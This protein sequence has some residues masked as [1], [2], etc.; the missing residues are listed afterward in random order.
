MRKLLFQFIL[1]I[2]WWV[3]SGNNKI[4]TEQW[5]LSITYHDILRKTPLK[6]EKPQIQWWIRESFKIDTL[7]ILFIT[8][9]YKIKVTFILKNVFHFNNG[10]LYCGIYNIAIIH[11]SLHRIY[12][13]YTQCVKLWCLF[14][15]LNI[16]RRKKLMKI[17]GLKR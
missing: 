3:V 4:R 5:F 11:C 17:K 14:I 10:H 8:C 6:L 13:L 1:L 15:F 16:M 2:D 12:S 9:I 7:W